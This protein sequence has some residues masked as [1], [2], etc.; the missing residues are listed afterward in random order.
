M[1]NSSS[2]PIVDW[3]GEVNASRPSLPQGDLARG[4]AATSLALWFGIFMAHGPGEERPLSRYTC[5]DHAWV[6]DRSKELTE[7]W[8]G[9]ES[10]GNGQM[11]LAGSEG[12]LF[13]KALDLNVARPQDLVVIPGIGPGRATAIVNERSRGPFRSLQDLERVSGVGP[14]TRARMRGWVRVE[15]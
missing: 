8:C 4:I 2:R 13:R 7:V 1:P 6:M 14:R 5:A 15:D 11:K 9:T 12:L 3:I 10:V